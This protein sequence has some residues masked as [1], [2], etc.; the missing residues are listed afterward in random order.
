[1]VKRIPGIS[2]VVPVHNEQENVL[3]LAEE[4]KEAL[5]ACYPY[6]LIFVDDASTD[7]THTLLLDSLKKKSLSIK[8]IKHRHNA[9]QSAAVLTGVHHAKYSWVATLDGDRQNDPRDIVNLI[10]LVE[11]QHLTNTLLMGVRINRQDTTIRKLSSR[12][13]NAIRRTLLQD[14]C[15]DSA[16]GIKLFPR[17]LFL[18]LPHFRNFHRFMPALFHRAGAS[19]L[20]VPVNHRPRVAGKSKYGISNRLWVGIIDL[21]GMAWL[22][23]RPIHV[24]AS[25]VSEN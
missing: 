23:R 25:D 9:G 22:M 2:I 12:L 17:D 6:E 24:E 15:P 20:N 7:N 19:I 8:I 1:M 16:C 10:H 14:N 18:A 5:A 13:A 4:V 21:I 3:P 11:Q